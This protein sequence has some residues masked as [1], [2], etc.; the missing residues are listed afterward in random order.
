MDKGTYEGVAAGVVTAGVMVTPGVMVA[1]GVL[2][3]AG[4]VVA[5]IVATGVDIFFVII[6]D[7]QGGSLYYTMH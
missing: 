7:S 3:T 6:L 4:M 5:G 1:P 2:V